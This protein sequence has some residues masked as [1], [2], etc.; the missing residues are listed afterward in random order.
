VQTEAGYHV[1][2]VTGITP[3][4]VQTFEEVRPQIEADLKRQKAAQRFATAAEKFQ[5]LVYEQ[6]DSLAPVAKELDLKLEATAPVTRSQVQAFALGNPKFVEALFSPESI[7]NKRNTEAVEVSPGVL[8]AGRIVDYMPAKPR[9][10]AEVQEQIREQLTRRAGSALAEKA[11][12]EK[13]ALLEKGKSDKEASVAFGKTVP[14]TRNLNAP[15]FSPET[16][17]S[18]FQAD[19]SKL[20]AYVGAP[21]ERGGYTIYRVSRVIDPPAPDAGKLAAAQSRVSDQIGRELMNAYVASLKSGAEVKI[22]E[23]SLEK[24]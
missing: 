4:R 10:L 20:P 18:I 9:P 3:P 19:P 7:Q 8:M 21:N 17:K 6:A 16:V 13:I 23:A 1:I 24:R 15:G 2:K 22:N 12:Q 14:L 11:G 5:N